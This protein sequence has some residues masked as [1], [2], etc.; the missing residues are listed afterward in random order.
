[1]A[2]AYGIPAILR[3]SRSQ[4]SGEYTMTAAWQVVYSNSA[5]YAWLFV[6]AEINLTPMIAGDTIDIRVRKINV[7]GGA[8][9]VHHLMPYSDVQ[10]VNHPSVHIG[11]LMDVFGVEVAMR[12]TAVGAALLNID[13]EFFDAF[14]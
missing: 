4:Q 14:R 3:A 2:T 9:I 10:P 11:P 6:S 12:Q 5:P 8:E 13:C 7:S 1:M